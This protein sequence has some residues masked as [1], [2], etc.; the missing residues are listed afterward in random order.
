MDEQTLNILL[1]PGCSAV[2]AGCIPLVKI[3]GAKLVGF[4]RNL[5]KS[6]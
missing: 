2:G 3:L 6:N 4:R 5:G 1:D